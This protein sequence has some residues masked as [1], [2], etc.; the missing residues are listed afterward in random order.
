[1]NVIVSVECLK[2]QTRRESKYL[3][4]QESPRTKDLDHTVPASS[5]DFG[6]LRVQLQTFSNY[7]QVPLP[8]I[9][10]SL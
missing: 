3:Y 4:Q 7:I 6:F 10:R 8:P 1:M 2:M 9:Y 5:R